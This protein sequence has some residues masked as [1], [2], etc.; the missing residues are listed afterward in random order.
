MGVELLG[1]VTG[2]VVFWFE[3]GFFERKAGFCNKNSRKINDKKIHP[4]TE[5]GCRIIGNEHEFVK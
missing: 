5:E 1:F 2:F 3:L 4:I